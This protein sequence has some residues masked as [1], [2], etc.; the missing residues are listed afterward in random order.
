MLDLNVIRKEFAEFL[1]KDPDARF[2]MDAALAHV[3]E[4]AYRQGIQD[5]EGRHK[6]EPPAGWEVG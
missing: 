5:A 2:R 1:A 6:I 3:V 4:L